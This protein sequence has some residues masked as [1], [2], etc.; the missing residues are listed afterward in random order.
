[1]N[2]KWSKQF[3]ATIW[4]YQAK[5]RYELLNFSMFHDKNTTLHF[6]SSCLQW[7]PYHWACLQWIPYHLAEGLQRRLSKPSSPLRCSSS[8]MFVPQ[9]R[10]TRTLRRT[11]RTVAGSRG[12]ATTRPHS[13]TAAPLQT[14]TI[15]KLDTSVYPVRSRQEAFREAVLRRQSR[16]VFGQL[17]G[18]QTSYWSP[19][20]PST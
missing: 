16:I 6:S 8:E 12:G 15:W 14:P 20:G 1:M 4:D 9:A 10:S 2:L 13:D 7:I 3:F 18:N 19:N 17:F 5:A 11:V